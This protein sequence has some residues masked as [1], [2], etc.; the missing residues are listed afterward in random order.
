M[1]PQKTSRLSNKHNS[2]EYILY[3]DIGNH[4]EVELLF[5]IKSMICN[6][7]P[8]ILYVLCDIR[9]CAS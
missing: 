8:N 9:R 3:F 1:T 6:T 4:E 5:I 2:N 7:Q